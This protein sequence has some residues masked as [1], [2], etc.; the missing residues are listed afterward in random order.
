MNNKLFQTFE[1]SGY[2]HSID[3][4]FILGWS[5]QLIVVDKNFKIWIGVAKQPEN[6]TLTRRFMIII[7]KN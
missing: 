7:M 2:I 5:I 6:Q 3:K 1:I 4:Y